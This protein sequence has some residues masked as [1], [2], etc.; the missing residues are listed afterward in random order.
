M[1]RQT[2]SPGWFYYMPSTSRCCDGLF[3]DETMRHT[4][5]YPACLV[6]VETQVCIAFQRNFVLRVYCHTRFCFIWLMLGWV[7]C[8]NDTKGC[9]REW[10]P[11]RRRRT[12][13]KEDWLT[14]AVL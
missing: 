12:R 1:Q 7:K 11:N 6:R 8:L 14:T 5:S 10:T 2:S 9:A 4:L 13:K 3:L